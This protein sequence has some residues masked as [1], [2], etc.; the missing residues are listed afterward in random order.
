MA[1]TIE[2]PSKNIYS[3][4][5]SKIRNNVIDNVSVPINIVSPKNYYEKNIYTE[6]KPFA[7]F[8][9][10]KS[11]SDI[12]D[13]GK[14][15]GP[16]QLVRY[17][18]F[19]YK[20]TLYY[21]YVEI[22]IPKTIENSYI[23]KIYNEEEKNIS[24]TVYGDIYQKSIEEAIIGS[25][26]DDY[27]SANGLST[28]IKY[29]ETILTSENKALQI[30][31][32]PKSVDFKSTNETYNFSSTATINIDVSD[33]TSFT[34][35]NDVK[36]DSY[37][38]TGKVL[39]GLLIE[40]STGYEEI[41]EGDYTSAIYT[42]GLSTFYKGK[43]VQIT[44]YGNTVGIDLK[45]D[46]KPFGNGNHPFS[47]NGN[48]LLQDSAKIYKDNSSMSVTEHLSQEILKRYEKGKETAVIL[49]GINST[50]REKA[51]MAYQMSEYVIPMVLGADGKD[52]PMSINKYGKPKTFEVVGTKIYYD[53]AVWQELTLQE[54]K[55]VE[56]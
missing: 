20:T 52:K 47:I 5:N 9:E 53:G 23:T 38:I 50:A 48:E 54:Y 27:E 22:L 15:S 24:F 46:S 2:I 30:P 36:N 35:T 45:E 28:P 1:I 34:V 26:F 37:I 43:E 18:G 25:G 17:A 4:N 49:C 41:Q 6:S 40:S 39:C 13:V 56:V 10:E 29:G 11:N 8:D 21:K 12:V 51:Y 31:K 7:K 55:E 3:I 16:M 14:G 19:Y 32:I 42:T 33:E 44:V